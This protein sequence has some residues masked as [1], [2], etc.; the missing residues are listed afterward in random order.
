LE[1]RIPVV[2]SYRAELRAY[3]NHVIEILQNRLEDQT[4]QFQPAVLL[5]LPGLE[6]GTDD[7]SGE[8]HRHAGG[9]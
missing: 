1:E 6:A 9:D 7:I 5:E 2:V 3:G 8:E 4:L